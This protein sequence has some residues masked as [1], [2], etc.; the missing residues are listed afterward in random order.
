MCSLLGDSNETMEYLSGCRKLAQADP[1][2]RHCKVALR[3]HSELC[4]KYWLECTGK[5]YDHQPFPVVENGKVREDNLGYD[6]LNRRQ[7]AEEQ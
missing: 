7:V 3:V 6:Y 4:R 5:W 2:K 1:R